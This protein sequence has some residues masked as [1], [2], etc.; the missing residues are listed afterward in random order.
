MKSMTLKLAQHISIAVA[1]VVMMQGEEFQGTNL[2]VAPPTFHIKLYFYQQETAKP[3][4]PFFTPLPTLSLSGNNTGTIV[5]EGCGHTLKINVVTW[6]NEYCDWGFLSAGTTSPV[7][8][9]CSVFILGFSV[10]LSP[11]FLI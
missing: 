10:L 8:L 1:D 3:P 11:K 4:T 2:A 9:R 5:Q 7:L 6:L